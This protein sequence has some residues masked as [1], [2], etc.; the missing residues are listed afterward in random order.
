MM[1]SMIIHQQ[2]SLIDHHL[3]QRLENHHHQHI[4]SNTI[5]IITIYACPAPCLLI[6]PPLPH[7]ALPETNKTSKDQVIISVGL[8]V[9]NRT[10][11]DLPL[12]VARE[13]SRSF[14]G[15]KYAGQVRL[16]AQQSFF[17]SNHTLERLILRQFGYDVTVVAQDHPETS[18]GAS[19]KITHV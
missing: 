18:P 2:S 15:S 1:I 9:S 14:R 13:I 11:S 12:S 8:L 7:L 17:A 6:L 4:C 10:P 3:L 16:F 19:V 5:I